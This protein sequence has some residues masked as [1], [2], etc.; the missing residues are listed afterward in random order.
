MVETNDVGDYCKV[1][2]LVAER[3]FQA[4]TNDTNKSNQLG[5]VGGSPSFSSSRHSSGE[6]QRSLLGNYRQGEQD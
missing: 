5:T 2:D 4:A 3:D 6:L 1:A